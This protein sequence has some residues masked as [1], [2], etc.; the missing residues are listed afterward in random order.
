MRE[1]GARQREDVLEVGVLVRPRAD[2]PV[3]LGAARQERVGLP[4]EVVVEVAAAPRWR[5]T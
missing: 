5:S 3:D 2:R 1:P 4:D